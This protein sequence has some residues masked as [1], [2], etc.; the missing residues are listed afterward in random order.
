[1]DTERLCVDVDNVVAQTDE[2]MRGIIREFSSAK[3]DLQYEDITCFDYWQCKDSQGRQFSRDEWP[4]IHCKFSEPHNILAIKPYPNVQVYLKQL[5]ARYEIHLVTSRLP[6]AQEAT[7]QWLAEHKF[8]AHILH[9]VNHREKHLLPIKFQAAIDDDREQARIFA[10]LGVRAFLLA[11]TW[12]V[13]DD[14]TPIVRMN[15]WAELVLA[16][17]GLKT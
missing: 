6:M 8:P 13:I 14:S 10:S 16:L 5:A 15:S 11:Q 1:M 4:S 9:F 17:L 7:I 3:V 12:N 2:V